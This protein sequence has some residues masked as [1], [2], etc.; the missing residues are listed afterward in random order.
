M[1]SMA[2][3]V[4]PPVMKPNPRP[5]R[6]R[7]WPKIASNDPQVDFFVAIRAFFDLIEPVENSAD[8]LGLPFRSLVGFEHIFHQIQEGFLLHPRRVRGRAR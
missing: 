1:G 4:T 6:S 3:K 7:A 2:Q 5:A 8:K